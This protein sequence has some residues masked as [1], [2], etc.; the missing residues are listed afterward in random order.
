MSSRC[1]AGLSGVVVA[2]GVVIRIDR[3]SLL[4][5]FHRPS[6]DL[7]PEVNVRLRKRA[8]ATGVPRL[9]GL[10][11]AAVSTVIVFAGCTTTSL[12]TPDRPPDQSSSKCQVTA[13]GPQNAVAGMGGSG[14]VTVN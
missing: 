8:A 7:G 5:L 11:I 13:T 10:F 2:G 1:S 9:Q 3:M 4:N 6:R 12:S 14:T